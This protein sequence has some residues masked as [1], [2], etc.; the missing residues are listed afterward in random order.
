MVRIKLIT[1][2]S[3]FFKVNKQA[4]INFNKIQ[5]LALRDLDINDE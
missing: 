2:V 4:K 5:I 1:L 3:D